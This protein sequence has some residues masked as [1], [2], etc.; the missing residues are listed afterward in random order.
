MVG[1]QRRQLGPVHGFRSDRKQVSDN[2]APPRPTEQ[3]RER[4]S[5]HLFAHESDSAPACWAA[6]VTGTSKHVRRRIVGADL[7]PEFVPKQNCADIGNRDQTANDAARLEIG[8]EQGASGLGRETS[9]AQKG[10]VGRA[11]GA[12]SAYPRQNKSRALRPTVTTKS[13]PTA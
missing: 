11:C 7:V 9:R 12:G 10:G 4:P 3:R 13:G 1:P 2:N 5:W 6:R 8:E